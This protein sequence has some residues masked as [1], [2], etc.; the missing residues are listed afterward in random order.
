[1]LGL[2][3]V[4][5]QSPFDLLAL[6]SIPHLIVLVF[7][8]GASSLAGPL[9]LSIH[10]H[11]HTHTISSEPSPLKARSLK[12][13]NLNLS[14]FHT[15]N[16]LPFS[17]PQ[18]VGVTPTFYPRNCV[19]SLHDSPSA[20]HFGLPPAAWL[21]DPGNIQNFNRGQTHLPAPRFAPFAPF[22][23]NQTVLGVVPPT[24]RTSHAQQLAHEPPQV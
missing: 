6:T 4:S 10:L 7:P 11:I 17:D 3:L 20:C 5:L 9:P 14:P 21:T 23:T 22:D 13:K 8:F 18:L 15:S 24:I 19:A 1:V 12:Q 16:H 2:G